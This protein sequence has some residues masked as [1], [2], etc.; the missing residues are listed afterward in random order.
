MTTIH[1]ED[2]TFAA[3][4]Y[5]MNAISELSDYATRDFDEHEAARW[6]LSESEWRAEMKL[7]LDALAA[8]TEE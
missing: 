5:D 6:G 7:A 3:A 4:C 8:E 2:N 1:I